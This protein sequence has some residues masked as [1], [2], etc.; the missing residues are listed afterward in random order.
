MAQYVFLYYGE[1]QFDSPE[2]AQAHQQEFFAWVRGLGEAVI[3]PG[4]PL[5]QPTVVSAAGVSSGDPASRLTGLSII[6]ADSLE[7]ATAMAQA[8][9]YVDVGGA[10][11]IAEVFQM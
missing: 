2:T 10:I 6:E 5:G 1:P 3:N 11:H 7:A 4:M 9:P 8:S